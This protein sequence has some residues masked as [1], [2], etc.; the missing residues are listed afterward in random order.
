MI[1]YWFGRLLC[2]RGYHFTGTM[3]QGTCEREGCSVWV[4]A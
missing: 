3:R 4:K 2:G 1:R